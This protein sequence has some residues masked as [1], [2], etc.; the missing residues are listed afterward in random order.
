[1]TPPH[2]EL[3]VKGNPINLLGKRLR[4]ARERRNMTQAEL[5]EVLGLV[6]SAISH[7]ETGSREPCVR[8]LKRLA[9]ALGVSADWLLDIPYKYRRVEVDIE[10]RYKF[11]KSQQRAIERLTPHEPNC[12][13]RT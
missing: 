13:E 11:T 3:D 12:Y 2:T 10:C 4:E 7:F 9:L 6:V 1:M 5:A 8:N